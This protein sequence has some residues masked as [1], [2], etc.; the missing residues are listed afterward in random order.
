MHCHDCG[1]YCTYCQ[2]LVI[3]LGS[4]LCRYVEK[5]AVKKWPALAGT[6]FLASAP[7]TGNNEL[8][9]RIMRAMPLKSVS[10][11][12]GA[13]TVLQRRRCAFICNLAW[14]SWIQHRHDCCCIRRVHYQVILQEHASCKADVLFG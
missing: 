6:A 2:L 1:T 4:H 13:Q 11:T 3:V 10:I 14:L 7:H 9:K 8:V 12:W 5:M